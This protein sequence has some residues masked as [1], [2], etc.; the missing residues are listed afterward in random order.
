MTDRDS[1]SET[2][3]RPCPTCGAIVTA[4]T[5][6]F[7]FCSERCRTMDLSRWASEDYRISRPIEQSDIE[8]LD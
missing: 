3:D 8:E 4:D 2:A 1:K 6:T 7:P 5:E